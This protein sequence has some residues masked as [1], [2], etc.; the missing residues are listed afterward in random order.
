MNK[1]VHTASNDIGFL[2]VALTAHAAHDTRR[3]TQAV[4][5]DL[6]EKIA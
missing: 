3:F 5:L 6:R 2:E 1:Y 4:T